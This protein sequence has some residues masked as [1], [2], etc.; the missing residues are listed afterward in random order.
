MIAPKP[1][2]LTTKVNQGL[3][4]KALFLFYIYLCSATC[5]FSKDDIQNMCNISVVFFLAVQCAVVD[6]NNLPIFPLSI[7]SFS[8]SYSSNEQSP[9]PYLPV[10]SI[11]MVLSVLSKV[12]LSSRARSFICVIISRRY[13]LKKI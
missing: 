10:H 1:P 4:L 5:V 13:S 3:P 8:I 11:I 6:R 2:T 9:G 7:I 12:P